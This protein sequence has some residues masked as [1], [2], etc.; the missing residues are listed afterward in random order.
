MSRVFDMMGQYYAA[1]SLHERLAASLIVLSIWYRWCST[2]NG[3]QSH[4]TLLPLQ[5]CLA[6]AS[7]PKPSLSLLGS[8]RRDGS[9][10]TR[11]VR[12]KGTMSRVFDMTGQYYAAIS[13]HEPL[14]A[15]LIVLS[16]CYRWCSTQN[17]M[18]SHGT[19]RPL[20]HCSASPCSQKLE[21]A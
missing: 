4:G 8:V 13:L 12:A 15:S 9:A 6:S 20:Q 14:A 19:L 11:V 1:M 18:Q 17:G 16:I 21:I 5:H 7:S 10:R 3:T 2:R